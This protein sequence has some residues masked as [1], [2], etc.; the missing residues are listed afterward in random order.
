ME[1]EVVELD[2]GNLLMI[3]RTQR[4][5][6]ATSQSTDGGDHWS[7]ASELPVQSPESPATI[8]RIPSTGDLLLVWNNSYSP[9]A[10]HGG[11]RT[12]LTAAI[13]S[14]QGRTWRFEHNLEDRIDEGYAYTSV[15]FY[16]DRVLLTYY[17]SDEKSRQ[18]SSRFRSLPVGWFYAAP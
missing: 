12:P 15:V 5:R 3:I 10:G 11:K 16:R 13:S 9:A 14:D 1:P 7:L 2:N 8:R 4:G 17:V 6:I 18:I